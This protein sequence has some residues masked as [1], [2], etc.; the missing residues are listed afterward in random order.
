MEVKTSIGRFF[1]PPN[2]GSDTSEPSGKG[3]RIDRSLVSV[4]RPPRRPQEPPRVRKIARERARASLS[5]QERTGPPRTY[6]R[7]GRPQ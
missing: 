2:E 6:M 4:S 1:K 7:A 3:R 5:L